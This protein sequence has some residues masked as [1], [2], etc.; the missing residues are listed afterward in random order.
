[1]PLPTRCFNLSLFASSAERQQKQQAE[2]D[3]L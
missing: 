3:K 1:M 2:I